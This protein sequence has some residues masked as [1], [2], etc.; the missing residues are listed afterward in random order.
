MLI[1]YIL[2]GNTIESHR[3]KTSYMLTPPPTLFVLIIKWDNEEC[4]RAKY[5]ILVYFK[6]F[7]KKICGFFLLFQ[8][9]QKCISKFRK[10]YLDSKSHHLK[11]II[12]HYIYI[13]WGRILRNSGKNLKK[14]KIFFKDNILL[15]THHN[16]CEI[17][18]TIFF[19]VLYTTPF[20]SL[21]YSRI[22]I[23]P[24]YFTTVHHNDKSHIY[25]YPFI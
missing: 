4:K 18:Q 16:F 19:S 8:Q 21:F 12:G 2:A 17:I 24:L 6:F 14:S 1:V 10:H 20:I 25:V 15:L 3:C 9:S 7:M 11:L 13:Y 22:S 5:L 23:H